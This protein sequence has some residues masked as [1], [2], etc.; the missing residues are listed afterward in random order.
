[1]KQTSIHDRMELVSKYKEDDDSNALK[2][3]D[4]SMTNEA[5]QVIQNKARNYF[6]TGLKLGTVMHHHRMESAFM[7]R[8]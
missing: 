6:R 8:E 4:Q 2:L 3:L 1:M 5:K 7:A